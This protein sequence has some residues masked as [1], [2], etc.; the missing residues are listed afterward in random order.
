MPVL[1]L[2]E[3]VFYTVWHYD[4][5][6]NKKSRKSLILLDFTNGCVIKYIGRLKEW[7]GL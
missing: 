6:C 2:C 5:P 7:R 3:I 4:A 1:Y